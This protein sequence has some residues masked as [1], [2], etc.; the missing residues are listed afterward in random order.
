MSTP[1]S[2]THLAPLPASAAPTRSLTAG[3]SV[4]SDAATWATTWSTLWAG[5]SQPP[6]LPAIDFSTTTVLLLTD[7]TKPTGGYSVVVE[8][9]A[10]ASGTLTVHVTESTPGPTCGTVQAFSSPA[11]VVTLAHH[12][13]ST[14]QFQVTQ[15]VAS[16]G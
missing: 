9:I 2:F 10:E 11:D 15:V 7:G 4:I 1:I 12:D 13:P 6:A 3:Q 5:Q 8:S 14:I 16:C